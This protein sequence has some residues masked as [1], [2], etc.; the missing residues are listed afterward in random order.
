MDVI[1]REHISILALN[2]TPL[3]FQHFDGPYFPT[4]RLLHQC[5]QSSI[6]KVVVSI[7]LIN[8]IAFSIIVYVYD[9]ATVDPELLPRVQVD[10]GA[11]KFVLAGANVMWCVYT[12]RIVALAC[13]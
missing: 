11:I 12:F 9:C 10:K 1:S 13:D 5:A 6:Y 2:G 8:D 7:R 3:F 4:L